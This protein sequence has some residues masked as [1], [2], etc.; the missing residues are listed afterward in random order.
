L[1]AGHLAAPSSAAARRRL[2]GVFQKD[3]PM[4]IRPY[5]AK[6]AA[7]LA[8]LFVQSVKTIGPR[9]YS[10][11]QVEAWLSLRPSP[12]RLHHLMVD[13]RTRLVAVDDSD[14]PIAFADLEN[15]GHIALLYCSPEMAGARVASALYEELERIARE[16]GVIRL[17]SEASEAARRLFLRKG[18]VVTARRQFE[19]SGVLIHNYAVE[20]ILGKEET[21]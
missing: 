6:D 21:E 16:R 3:P 14:Q 4:E 19:I 18:F 11:L 2:E 10:S 17:H 13:G 7:L 9:D 5:D 15:D 20:K 12:E 1:Q 8:D